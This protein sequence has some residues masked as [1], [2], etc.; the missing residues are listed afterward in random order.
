MPAFVGLLTVRMRL[1]AQSLKE[2]RMVVKSAVERVRGR[3]NASAAEV[4]DLD[5]HGFATIAVACVSNER[6]HADSMVQEIARY[7]EESRLDAEILEVETE[8]V[9]L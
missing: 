7:L 5:A 1:P 9:A 3:Y 8:V 6:S 2:K 4:E